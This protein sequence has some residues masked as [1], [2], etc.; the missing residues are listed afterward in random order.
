MIQLLLAAKKN[1][2]DPNL[3]AWYKLDGNSN[4]SAGTNNGTD[5][6]ISY[7][8]GR[9]WNAASFNG[10]SSSISCWTS[11]MNV[12]TWDFTIWLLLNPSWLTVYQRII[13]KFNLWTNV[14][15]DIRSDWS[16]S[17]KLTFYTQ[18]SWSSNQIISPTWAL[19]IWSRWY[20]T[21]T[22]S[23]WVMTIY[24]NWSS[25]ATNTWST[26]DIS[27][28]ATLWMGRLD[29]SLRYNWLIDEVKIYNRVLSA[30]EISSQS[31]AYWF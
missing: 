29:A 30:G 4:D 24:K 3:I 26:I 11:L 23:W 10:T 27:S 9:V 17:T 28:T 20:Y 16:D 1:T 5:T 21:F 14:W 22:R 8:T 7:V 6:S 18:N 19:V 31:T 25:I 12:W 13:N 15:F 2:I